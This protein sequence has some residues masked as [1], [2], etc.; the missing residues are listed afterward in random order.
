MCSQRKEAPGT[1]PGGQHRH[2]L[3]LRAPWPPRPGS[4]FLGW[5]L[6]EPIVL[7]VDAVTWTSQTCL[8]PTH[9]LTPPPPSPWTSCP[10]KLRRST[11]KASVPICPGGVCAPWD[12]TMGSGLHWVG[13]EVVS[14]SV[15]VVDVKAATWWPGEEAAYPGRP[16]PAQWSLQCR[17][18]GTVAWV[19]CCSGVLASLPPGKGQGVEKGS[20]AGRV[21]EWDTHS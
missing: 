12:P 6:M 5:E 1:R 17:T 21:G 7:Q 2:P 20:R 18:L 3:A 13:G 16:S 14:V 11:A 10:D 9:V 15:C 4:P 8:P 19:G